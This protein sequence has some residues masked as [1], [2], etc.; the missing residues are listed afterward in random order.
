[1]SGKVDREEEY[2]ADG[3]RLDEVRPERPR[4]DAELARELRLR[5][6][7]PRVT[8]LSRRMLTI[9]GGTSAV[10]VAAALM[11]A[12]WPHTPKQAGEELLSTENRSTPDALKTLPHDYSGLP[13]TS[14]PA[15][16]P[17][18]PQ[19]GQPLPGDLGRPM[20]NAG[21][22]TPGMPQPTTS[23]Q[24]D[25]EA[26]RRTQERA[27]RAQEVDAARSS[28]L[29]TSEATAAVSPGPAVAASTGLSAPPEQ[30]AG[31]NAAR[32][33]TE[34]DRKL[35]FLNGDV[36]RRTVSQDRVEAPA[37]RNVVQAGAVIPAALLT[38][39]RSDLPGQITAQVTE[40][41]YDSPTGRTL[42][43]PQGARLIGTY[44]AQVQFG[45]SRALLVWTRLIYPD[46]RSVVLERQPGA[47]AGGYAGLQDRVD[48]H[49]GQLFKAAL[50]STL[51]SVGTEAGTSN[52]ENSLVQAIREGASNSFAQ[53]GSQVVGRSLTIQPTLTIRPGFPVR[54]VVTRDLIL[55]PYGG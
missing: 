40:A 33:P 3:D 36:D 22:A 24:P 5:P 42:L 16:G 51:L 1:M 54:V 6:E 13:R 41:V 23:A 7:P 38:G 15:T 12:L 37:S 34:G 35:A 46:G 28:K 32:Q 9:L 44:D 48:S 31:A 17:G 25:P 11:L 43:I 18:V 19:L 10:A 55:E 52:N 27:R 39:L 26:Q 47:D 49:W 30:A 53:T 14:V 4:S 20:L 2:A 21:V 45:Q 50:L 29:F 8:R